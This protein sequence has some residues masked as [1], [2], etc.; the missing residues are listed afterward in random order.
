MAGE[1]YASFDIAITNDTTYEGNEYFGLT[2]NQGM[3]NDDFRVRN[4]YQAN[5]TIV[6]DDRKL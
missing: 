4:P 2:I 5:V 3:L 6:D 1:T